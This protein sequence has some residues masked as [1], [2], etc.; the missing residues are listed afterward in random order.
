MVSLLLGDATGQA[1]ENWVALVRKRSGK[2][3]PSGF[4]HRLPKSETM[5]SGFLI[6]TDCHELRYAY[7]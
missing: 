3:R 4:P 1:F 2:Y 7:D 6:P 5:P